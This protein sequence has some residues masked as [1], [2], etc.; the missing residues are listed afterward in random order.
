MFLWVA[1]GMVLWYWVG[2]RA[3]INYTNR[4]NKLYPLAGTDGD[5]I[6]NYTA[7]VAG[8]LGW[9]ANWFCRREGG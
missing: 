5:R 2:L 3:T 4:L 8:P 7:A 9:V 1:L 6:F